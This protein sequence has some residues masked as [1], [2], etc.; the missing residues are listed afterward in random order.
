MSENLLQFPRQ[1]GHLVEYG[2]NAMKEGAAQLSVCAVHR[3]GRQR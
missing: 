3:C 2:A 1:I